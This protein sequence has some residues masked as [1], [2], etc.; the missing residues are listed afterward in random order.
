MKLLNFK[1][2]KDNA[3]TDVTLKDY[4]SYLD[5][6][7]VEVE[8]AMTTARELGLGTEVNEELVAKI[9]FIDKLLEIIDANKRDIVMQSIDKLSLED[10]QSL[11]DNKIGQYERELEELKSNQDCYNKKISEAEKAYNKQMIEHG[12]CVDNYDSSDTAEFFEMSVSAHEYVKT[13]MEQDK[14]DEEDLRDK[15]SIALHFETEMLGK[16][17]EDEQKNRINDNIIKCM[18]DGI[19]GLFVKCHKLNRM[20]SDKSEYIVNSLL[21]D[22]GISKIIIEFFKE[23]ITENLFLDIQNIDRENKDFFKKLPAPVRDKLRYERFNGECYKGL[24]DYY[25][26]LINGAVD[27]F[28]P[29]DIEELSHLYEEGIEIGKN[30]ELVE[31]KIELEKQFIQ[32]KEKLRDYLKEHIE[33]EDTKAPSFVRLDNFVQIAQGGMENE[34]SRIS[35]ITEEMDQNMANIKRLEEILNTPTYEEKDEKASLIPSEML[36]EPFVEVENARLDQIRIMI[37]TQRELEN[38]GEVINSLK[39]SKVK[40]I[41]SRSHKQSLTKSI[42]EYDACVLDTF[43]KLDAEGIVLVEAPN[44]IIDK[45]NGE[46]SA[47]LSKNKYPENFDDLSL[48]QHS[49]WN[50]EEY[51]EEIEAYGLAKKDDITKL[52]AIQRHC[53]NKLFN[54]SKDGDGIYQFTIEDAERETLLNCQESIVLIAKALYE[55]RSAISQGKESEIN[56]K[57]DEKTVAELRGMGL[58]AFT[59]E[60]LQRTIFSLTR[61]N[62]SLK[63]EKELL[64]SRCE[65]NMIEG[66]NTVEEAILY[67]DMLIGINEYSVSTDEIL[68]VLKTR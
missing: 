7:K 43:S 23:D 61:T 10:L 41:V 49:F 5:S 31:S 12:Y 40:N 1:E 68:G 26:A 8:E 59:K 27:E 37:D 17:N 6:N 21:A 2:F 18:I 39:S 9:D 60:D 67:R 65:D 55:K 64:V 42:R 28:K 57:I 36:I 32:D 53:V 25:Y 50:L 62:E 38:I 33:L 13:L 16:E 34:M 20:L 63:N 15:L 44:L 45:E 3:T 54:Y 22:N 35:S 46:I 30:I 4:L 19:V 24:F 29:F 51:I 56:H 58:E 52:V 47:E 11:Y 48:V 14:L 66:I